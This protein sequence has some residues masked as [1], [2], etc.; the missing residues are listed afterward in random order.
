VTIAAGIQLSFTITPAGGPPGTY[1]LKVFWAAAITC[2]ADIQDPF[3]T[4]WS[5]GRAGDVAVG[6]LARAT[7][8]SPRTSGAAMMGAVKNFLRC[9]LGVRTLFCL[10]LS[11]F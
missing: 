5:E 4:I 6:L 3:K 9:S 11:E 2:V 10:S 8:P 1:R 7:P